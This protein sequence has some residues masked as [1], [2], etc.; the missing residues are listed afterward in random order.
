MRV[1]E[2]TRCTACSLRVLAAATPS[3]ANPS[4]QPDLVSPK[5]VVCKLDASGGTATIAP[6]QPFS[7][8]VLELSGCGKTE[9][10]KFE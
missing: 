2:G 6:L 5:T 9:D 1:S 8:S 4:W 10:E 7:Y 3:A